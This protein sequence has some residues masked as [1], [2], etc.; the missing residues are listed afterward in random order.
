MKAKYITVDLRTIRGFRKA[1]NLKSKGWK[2]TSV[3]FSTIQLMRSNKG[4][5]DIIALGFI[6]YLVLMV[7]VLLCIFWGGG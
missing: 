3:G 6:G 4:Q 5:S 1:E 7:I 2:I